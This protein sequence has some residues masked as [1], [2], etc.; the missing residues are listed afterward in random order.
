MWLIGE[1]VLTSCGFKSPVLKKLMWRLH[2]NGSESIGS[3]CRYVSP[4]AVPA[5]GSLLQEP[6]GWK[7][8]TYHIEHLLSASGA[9]QT[10]QRA[11]SGGVCDCVWRPQLLSR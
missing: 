2:F 1:T 9:E 4:G 3:G 7:R 5:L 10:R 6:L 8:L 11:R